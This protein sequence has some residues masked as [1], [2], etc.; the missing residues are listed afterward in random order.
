[1][2]QW[3]KWASE[4]QSLAQA[5]LTYG[6][7]RFDLE[8]Y[9]RIREISAEMMARQTELPLETVRD[10]FCEESGYQT[11]KVDVRAAVFRE[12]KLLLVQ[13]ENGEWSL[14]GGWADIH[15]SAAENAAKECA[16]E[17]GVTVTVDRLIA[18]QDR[19]K[20]NLPV[21]A[22]SIYKIFFH[23]TYVA[24]D[25]RENSETRDSRWFGPEELPPLSEGRNNREQ[26]LMCFDAHRDPAWEPR[27]D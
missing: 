3:L 2:E 21:L 6:H 11:P 1:M 24:G 5:G 20:H 7:D 14:P 4:L 23:C 22:H 13:E 8:R 12:G 10:L 16:E 25:F 9:T 18:V 27:F 15:L 19:E 17:A 26:I